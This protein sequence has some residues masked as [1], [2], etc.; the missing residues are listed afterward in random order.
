MGSGVKRYGS[1]H[2]RQI[3][4]MEL[5]S[6]YQLTSSRREMEGGQLA[7]RIECPVISIAQFGRKQ[8]KLMVTIFER[9]GSQRKTF[10][11]RTSIV[12][13]AHQVLS[14]VLMYKDKL[15]EFVQITQL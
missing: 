11:E 12:G 6:C 8:E 2:E 7:L 3:Y 1:K 5:E 13:R 14:Q 9:L 15:S 10:A 4:H